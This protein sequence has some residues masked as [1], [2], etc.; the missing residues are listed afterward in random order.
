MSDSQGNGKTHRWRPEL[1]LQAFVL[2]ICVGGPCLG[3]FT[4]MNTKLEAVSTRQEERFERLH[5]DFR[6]LE[7]RL[8]RDET[9]LEGK[10]DTIDTRLRHVEQLTA[11]L[12]SKE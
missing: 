1:I 9:S 4:A 3:F 5:A 8:A 7:A 2:A 6:T 12:A 11:Q 10:L